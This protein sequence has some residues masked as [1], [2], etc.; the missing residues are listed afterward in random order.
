MTTDSRRYIIKINGAWLAE[1]KYNVDFTVTPVGSGVKQDAEVYE[2]LG[3]VIAVLREIQLSG[4]GVTGIIV[5]EA[6]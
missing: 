3:G 2:G 4:V 6:E 1:F 5:E